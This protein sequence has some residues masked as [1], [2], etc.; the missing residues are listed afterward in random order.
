MV[1]TIVLAAEITPKNSNKIIVGICFV[2]AMTIIA[3]IAS[4]YSSQQVEFT[5]N[6]NFLQVDWIKL[7]VY[8]KKEDKKISWSEI[9]SYK[10]EKNPLFNEFKITL[11]NNEK[12]SFSF[13]QSGDVKTFNEF[14][15]AFV[16]KIEK[17]KSSNGSAWHSSS[18]G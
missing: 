8:Q 11:T 5:I 1:P 18:P 2:V 12:F 7:P 16:D 13:S 3:L 4:K 6:E 9:G 17:N 10:Y 15:Q 14:Y